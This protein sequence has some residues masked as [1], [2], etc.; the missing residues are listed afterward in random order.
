MP[1]PAAKTKSE[2]WYEPEEVQNRLDEEAAK[3]DAARGGVHKFNNLR[4]FSDPNGANWTANFG[5]RGVASGFS[6]SVQLDEMREVLRRVQME[7][8]QIAFPK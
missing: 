5:G 7:M 2:R 8:P 6:D 1:A 3:F 4:R